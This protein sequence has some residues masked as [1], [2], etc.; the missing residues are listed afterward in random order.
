MVASTHLLLSPVL[1]DTRVSEWVARDDRIRLQPSPERTSLMPRIRTSAR[2][3][4]DE[5][6]VDVPH[7][8][9]PMAELGS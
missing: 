9:L 7:V 2:S 6:I 3:P 8:R 5:S 4:A 1:G